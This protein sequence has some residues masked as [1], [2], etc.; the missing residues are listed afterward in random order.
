MAETPL[1][2]LLTRI[3]FESI[4]HPP[5]HPPHTLS[6][7]LALK[8]CCRE[9]RI[10]YA[11]MMLSLVVGYG[12]SIVSSVDASDKICSGSDTVKSDVG[13]AVLAW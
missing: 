12:K 10:N 7:N 6:S 8:R 2:K 13:V 5:T 3:E 11:G 9:E 4:P 1:P